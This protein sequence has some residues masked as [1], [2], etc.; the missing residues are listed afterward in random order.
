MAG[1]DFGRF[2]V[3]TFDC[4]GT[5]IDWERGLLSALWPVLDRRGVRTPDDALLEAFAR[6]ESELDSVGEPHPA[7]EDGLAWL[8]TM[9]DPYQVSIFDA[10]GRVGIY[11]GVYGVPETFVVKGDGTIAYRFAGLI[12]ED[13]YR[14]VILPE[15]EKALR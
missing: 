13:S 7:I 8:K 9:G 4:Y 10:D 6:F 2:D 11:Y 12:S 14:E 15:I 1:I 3:L 5:L